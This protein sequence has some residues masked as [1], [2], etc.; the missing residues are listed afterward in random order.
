MTVM[1]ANL[2]PSQNKEVDS[3]PLSLRNNGHYPKR[4]KREGHID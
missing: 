3:S 1:T 2:K 4:Y